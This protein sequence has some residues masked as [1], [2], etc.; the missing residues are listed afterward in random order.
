MRLTCVVIE[1]LNSAWGDR[2]FTLAQTAAVVFLIL[3][4]RGDTFIGT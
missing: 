3:H 4:Y 2:L 1:L